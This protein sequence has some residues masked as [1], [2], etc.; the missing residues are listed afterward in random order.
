LPILDRY[1]KQKW[2]HARAMYVGSMAFCQC[3]LML[4]SNR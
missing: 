2:Q 4:W 1:F 3:C